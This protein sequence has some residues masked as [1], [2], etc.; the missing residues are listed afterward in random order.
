[1]KNA[2]SI[3]GGCTETYSLSGSFT[4]PDVW[5][6]TYSLTFTGPDCSCFGGALGTPC[7]NQVYAVTAH[8]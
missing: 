1:M 8:K 7:I 2:G 6:G 4:G 3:P 5:S